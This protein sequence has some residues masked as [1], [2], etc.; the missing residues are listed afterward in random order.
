MYTHVTLSLYSQFVFWFNGL[1]FIIIIFFILSEMY[2]YLYRGEKKD[3]QVGSFKHHLGT[4][5]FT[6]CIRHKLFHAIFAVG[7]LIERAVQ[8]HLVLNNL[9]FNN[10]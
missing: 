4:V 8:R 10:F 9:I 7:E 5:Y 3:M 2:L 1:F 6:F